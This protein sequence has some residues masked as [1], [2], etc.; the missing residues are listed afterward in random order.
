[1]DIIDSTSL[2]S[3]RVCLRCADRV[4]I[5]VII[6]SHNHIIISCAQNQRR[7]TCIL[8]KLYTIDVLCLWEAREA[9]L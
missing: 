3:A 5:E 7:S 8:S 1:M 6:D 4:V 9:I 2:Q